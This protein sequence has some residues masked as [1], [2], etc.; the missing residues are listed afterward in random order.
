M[1]LKKI[2]LKAKDMHHMLYIAGTPYKLL[3][4]PQHTKHAQ[5]QHKQQQ[6]QIQE[7][8]WKRRQVAMQEHLYFLS[9]NELFFLS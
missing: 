3:R 6:K 9:S 2:P 5:W 8:A 1:Q 4:Q 7:H